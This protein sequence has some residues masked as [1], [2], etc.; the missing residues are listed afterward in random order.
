MYRSPEGKAA[1][2]AL[3]DRKLDRLQIEYDSVEVDTTFGLTHLL[4]T[5]PQDGPPLVLIHGANG[6][7]PVAL[8][9]YPRLSERF[10]VYAV[11]VVGEPNRS[12]DRRMPKKDRAYG[13]WLIEVLEALDL[14]AVVLVGF[15]LGGMV[16][17]QV[18]AEDERRIWSAY[19]AAPAGIVN[20]NPFTGIFRLFLPMKLFGKTGKPKHLQ[21]VLNGLFTERDDFAEPFLSAVIRN[22]Q[23]DFSPIKLISKTEAQRITT[24]MTIFGAEQDLMFPGRKLLKHA[25]RIFPGLE[26]AVLLEGSRH[27][28]GRADNDRIQSAVLRGMEHEE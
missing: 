10:R 22:F 13:R 4:V 5:G 11:D 3:Y 1:I 16:I 28:Q 2:L 27:V 26:D 7:A 6:C 17:W 23:L 20:G 21:K 12:H 25:R 15:S 14:E 9:V 18:L 19:L 24:P 8:D